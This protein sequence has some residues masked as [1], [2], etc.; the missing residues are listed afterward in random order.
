MSAA[1]SV[2]DLMRNSPLVALRGR[3]AT[4]A[5]ARL[6]AKL[7]LALPGGM[8]DRVALQMVLDAEAAGQLQPGGLIVESSSGT[9][10][11]GLARVGACRG[12]RVIIV[13]DPRI[14]LLTRTKLEALG[15]EVVVVDEQHPTG[16]WQLARLLRL[17]EILEQHPEAFWTRQY[18]NPSNPGAYEV[19]AA[20]L[21]AAPGPPIDALVA[22]VGSGGSLSGTAHALR[23][24]LPGLRVVAVD[25]VGSVLFHQPMRPRL[26]SGHGNNVVAGNLDY[27]VI[28]QVHWLADAEA[29]AGCR[30][31]ARREGIFA[32][33]SSGAVYVVASWVTQQLEPG[34]QV[35]A[36]LPD[37]GDRYGETIFSATFRAARGL[38]E[39]PLPVSPRQLRYGVD[40]AD[41]WSW[42]ELPHDG[43]QPYH[44][45][46]VARTQEL[47]AGWYPPHREAVGAEHE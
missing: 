38:D 7:E 41:A 37:R 9:L 8:K 24:Q 34:Q 26:Q 31:L 12:Y 5:R 18:D 45:P 29:F 40:A 11:E 43:S 6:W 20:E 42:A 10:A 44:A 15:T 32:G 47:T 35:V 33:G 23:R 14:D 30:E 21:L 2:L 3:Q 17:R 19:L 28:D 22:S 16:G 13:T 39:A 1:S 46:E 25:A 4:P 27:T 36:L